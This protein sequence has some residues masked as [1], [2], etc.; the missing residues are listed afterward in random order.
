M[1][2]I[3]LRLRENLLIYLQRIDAWCEF[4]KMWQRRS[5]LCKCSSEHFQNEL[6]LTFY[7]VWFNCIYANT[8][9]LQ[10]CPWCIILAKQNVLWRLHCLFLNFGQKVNKTV[11]S[12][13]VC[14][15]I[16][17]RNTHT[18]RPAQWQTQSSTVLTF[19]AFSRRFYTKRLTISTLVIRS[20]T[21][22]LSVTVKMFIEPSAKH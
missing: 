13:D 12:W 20:E 10:T 17:R 8:T 3:N 22:Y 9:I 5:V 18:C 6:F 1:R 4:T 21:I 19:R 15:L 2:L 7:F 14:G 11:C 16:W